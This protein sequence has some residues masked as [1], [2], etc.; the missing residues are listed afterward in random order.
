MPF[1]KL[2]A[3]F[4]KHRFAAS[5][6]SHETALPYRIVTTCR[7]S[8]V[9]KLEELM[10]QLLSAYDVTY[11]GSAPAVQAHLTSI[12]VEVMCSVRE[13]GGLVQLVTRV[14]REIS[15]RSVRWE[16]IPQRSTRSAQA[17]SASCTAHATALPA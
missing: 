9:A 8:E 11:Q 1:N 6:A 5:N 4:S 17:K 3:F 15:V 10:R 16:S 7:S 12:T 14:A 2:R 13:R